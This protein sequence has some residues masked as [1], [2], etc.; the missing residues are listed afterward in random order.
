MDTEMIVVHEIPNVVFH[1]PTNTKTVLF[2][3]QM[4]YRSRYLTMLIQNMDPL[5]LESTIDLVLSLFELDVVEHLVSVLQKLE[6]GRVIE[7][8]HPDVDVGVKMSVIN[9]TLGM[10]T[11]ANTELFDLAHF[12]DIPSVQGLSLKYLAETRIKEDKK[13]H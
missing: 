3:R 8:M 9:D 7:P 1:N 5:P 10:D 6:T 13:A 2:P 4:V 12:L 11:N